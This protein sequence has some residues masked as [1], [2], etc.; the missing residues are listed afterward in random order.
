MLIAAFLAACSDRPPD[1]TVLIASPASITYSTHKESSLLGSTRA[2][3]NQEIAAA[4]QKHCAQYGKTAVWVRT[5]TR[6]SNM[7]SVTYDCQALT[8]KKQ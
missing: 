3:T 5:I 8:E 4:A 2:A 1:L 7:E 6:A